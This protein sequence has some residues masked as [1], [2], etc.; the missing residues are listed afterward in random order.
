MDEFE[1]L[2]DSKEGYGEESLL[3]KIMDGSSS[4]DN[5]FFMMATN[6]IDKVPESI[7]RRP[8]RVKY[9]IEVTGI[10][11]TEKISR[12]LK[13]SFD[14]VNMEVDFSKDLINLKGKT[15]DELK[16]YVLDKI[17]NTS[18]EEIKVTKIGFKN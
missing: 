14:K 9:C 10:V 16:Q 12:F 7:R 5:V 18:F 13:E 2:V 6:Y 17:M 3:K 8:S 15:L 4:I 1:E 11:N